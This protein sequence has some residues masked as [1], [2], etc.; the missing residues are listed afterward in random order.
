MKSVEEL[1]ALLAE[2]ITD[3][4]VPILYS[5]LGELFNEKAAAIEAE[6]M[7]I[8]RALEGKDI[9]IDQQAAYDLLRNRSW[10]YDEANPGHLS[11]KFE[12]RIAEAGLSSEDRA[13]KRGESDGPLRSGK[14][15]SLSSLMAPMATINRAMEDLAHYSKGELKCSE[16]SGSGWISPKPKAE[17]AAIV[18]DIE[19]RR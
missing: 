17:E 19:V 2:F 18:T 8:I 3:E 11:S 12:K 16:C 6:R 10:A 7:A 14:L 13:R 15:V 4:A 5:A 1:K 9:S